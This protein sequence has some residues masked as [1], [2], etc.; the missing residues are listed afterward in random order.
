MNIIDFVKINGHKT[1]DELAFN[2]VDGLILAQLSYL[3]Y[4]NIC[5]SF[6]DVIG[7][8]SLNA[9]ETSILLSENN[10]M[11]EKD[12][13]RL[14][15][16]V[17]SCKRYYGVKF[18]H[19]VNDHN[20][21]Q[22]KQF[23]AITFIFENFI[24]VSFMGTDETILGWKED[25]NMSYLKC[26]PSQIEGVDYINK[27][28]SIYNKSLYITGHSKGGNIAGYAAC[29]C[30][31]EVK[32][33]IIKTYCY[34]APG[35]NKD[36]V[37]SNLYLQMLAKIETYLPESSFIGLIMYADN[38]YKIVASNKMFMFQHNPYNWLVD[39]T[40]FIFKDKLSK[41]SL[42]FSESNRSWVESFSEEEKKLFFDTLFGL[43][44]YNESR[45]ILELKNNFKDEASRIIK[46]SKEISEEHKKLMIDI[47]KNMFSTYI[48]LLFSK[49]RY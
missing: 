9:Y 39:S 3:N 47:T 49:K 25:F 37:S 23:G 32:N 35:F 11:N 18:G 42:A 48:K 19:Y 36:F 5:T 38:N 1:F 45:S 4:N 15:R 7:S 33:R 40:S 22:E 31:D 29:N 41:K 6:E 20:L 12:N 16:E 46:N 43:L 24:C 2:E 13:K 21:E 30:N 8:V 17:L 26:I 28:Y 14:I 44:E 34:D 10:F 27:I